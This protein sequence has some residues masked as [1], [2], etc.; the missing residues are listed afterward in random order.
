MS[1]SRKSAAAAAPDSIPV[2]EVAKAP[3][4]KVKVTRAQLREQGVGRVYAD[5][6]EARQNPPTYTPAAG[7]SYKLMTC[8]KEGES[9][10][11]VWSID[12]RRGHE[13]L[14]RHL[15]WSVGL[16]DKTVRQ[17]QVNALRSEND[18]LRTQLEALKAKLAETNGA[19]VS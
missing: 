9:D 17:S 15:G 2:A 3:E 10:L 13:F 4:G 6:E 12:T 11:Y 19:H 1:K 7:S 8:S 5:L 18:D 14:S 16:T